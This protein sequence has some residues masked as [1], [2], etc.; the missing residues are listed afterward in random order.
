MGE[1]I[2]ILAVVLPVLAIVGGLVAE[3]RLRARPHRNALGRSAVRVDEYGT[4]IHMLA[5]SL[6]RSV[7]LVRAGSVE[8]EARAA[9]AD[10]EERLGRADELLGERDRLADAR[11]RT[12]WRTRPEELE[13]AARRWEELEHDAAGL[14]DG[15]RDAEERCSRVLAASA[16]LG[17]GDREAV[18]LAEQGRSAAEEARARGYSVDG[19]A[20]VLATAHH[21]LEDVRRLASE[22]RPMAAREALTGL[23]TE[24]TDVLSA[25]RTIA[26]RESRSRRRLSALAGA[27]QE[28]GDRRTA[29]VAAVEEL[30]AGY[31]AALSEGL[32]ARLE[33]GVRSAAEVAEQVQDA[34]AGLEERDVQRAEAALDAAEEA[35]RRA[36]EEYGAADSRLEE[37]RELSASVPG[38][39]LQTLILVTEL[40][41]RAASDKGS[42]HLS[43][44][45][46]TLRARVEALDVEGDRPDWLRLQAGLDEAEELAASLSDAAEAAV[47]AA[48]K[49]RAEIDRL[50][51]ALRR[52]EEERAS[53]Q[54]FVRRELGK[55]P[56]AAR[57]GGKRTDDALGRALERLRYLEAAAERHSIAVHTAVFNHRAAAAAA[58]DYAAA[59]WAAGRLDEAAQI[60]EEARNRY[61]GSVGQEAVADLRV[62]LSLIDAERAATRE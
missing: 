38:R 24:L 17:D 44:A 46:Q 18:R 52:S 57:T 11:A 59:M 41:E 7:E 31:A 19:E 49:A 12:T 40:A 26:D 30:T 10:A 3:R 27:G 28:N 5:E 4:Q 13:R 37:V 60:A 14:L 36:G 15:L 8:E 56:P 35:H 43:P 25:L 32:Q 9:L 61:A 2:A 51:G 33:E 54:D 21:R 55:V 45:L 6:R 58:R 39:R 50:E 42:E 53:A 22:G 48:R 23:T 47:G 1:F 62:V 34:Q 20:S 16:S 29:A